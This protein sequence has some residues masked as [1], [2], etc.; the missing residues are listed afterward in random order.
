MAERI[1]TLLWAGR[2]HVTTVGAIAGEREQG[3]L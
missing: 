2:E 3:T 1:E